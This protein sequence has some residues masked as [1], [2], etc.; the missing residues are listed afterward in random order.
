MSKWRCLRL[1]ASLERTIRVEAEG[2]RPRINARRFFSL[3][4]D[5]W[6]F[7]EEENKYM[8]LT[9]CSGKDAF[10]V[11]YME[12]LGDGEIEQSRDKAESLRSGK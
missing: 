10:S 7:E 12:Y 9:Y 5:H 4:K 8:Y 2:N 3:K 11:V 1:A 6:S